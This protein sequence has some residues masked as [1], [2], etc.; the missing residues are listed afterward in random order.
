MNSTF[1]SAGS[2]GKQPADATLIVGGTGKSG[3]RVAQRLTA[4]GV[5]VRIG[6]RS[7][8]PPFD[9][10][11][12]STWAPAL[13]NVAAAYVTYF[14]DLAVPGAVE[15]VR[16]FS[17]LA[18]ESGVRRLVLLSGRGEEEA[19]KGEQAVQDSGAD[20]TIV[21]ASWFSQ[22][23]SEN[24]LLQSMIDGELALPAG[25]VGEPFIDVEDI[26]DVAVAALT[27]DVHAGQVYE[28]TGP[29]LLTFGEA[30]A[31]I[32]RATGR[33]IRYVQISHEAFATGLS[34][35][36]VPADFVGLVTY[37]FRQ[38]LDG[39]NARTTDG[40][41]R[42]LGRQPRD[43]AEYARVTADTGVWSRQPAEVLA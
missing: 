26:A 17:E 37:L 10:G 1:G 22:N 16:E 28:V 38:V 20:W 25:G 5:G 19:Q 15:A 2:K 31:E 9:W 7:G 8:T 11:D 6:S 36:G 30:V 14:P 4:L 39:R 21:R 43:F 12:P 41:E 40:V 18:V 35:Q 42:A 34:E 32:A 24:F 3:R 33:Q 27:E 13:E 29:R 23:F